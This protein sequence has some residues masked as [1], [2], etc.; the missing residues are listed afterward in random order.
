MNYDLPYLPGVT[1]DEALLAANRFATDSDK[2]IFRSG[3][4]QS[5]PGYVDA[6]TEFKLDGPG[7]GHITW[8]TNRG[9]KTEAAGTAGALYAQK[10]GLWAD[11]TPPAAAL[12]RDA[13]TTVV[14]EAR[15]YFSFTGAHNLSPGQRI[16]LRTAD[17]GGIQFGDD[18]ALVDA[19]YTTSGS[20]LVL[21]NEPGHD[22]AVGDRVTFTGIS[23]INGVNLAGSHYAVV[24]DDNTWGVEVPAIATGSSFGGGAFTVSHAPLFVVETVVDADTITVAAP[25]PASAS[26]TAAWTVAIAFLKPGLTNGI[27]PGGYGEGGYGTGPYGIDAVPANKSFFRPRNWALDTWGEDLLANPMGG[28]L[29][30]WSPVLSQRAALVPNAPAQIDFMFVTDNRQVMC[31][32]CTNTGGIYDPMLV[33]WSE[34]ED[35]ELWFPSDT[36]LAGDLRLQQGSELIGAIN[37]NSGFVILSD[38]SLYTGR[39]TGDFA[40]VY[41]IDF[42]AGECGLIAPRALT[43]KDGKVHWMTKTGFYSYESGIPKRAN[44]PVDVWVIAQLSQR[45][46]FKIHA[47]TDA[48]DPAVIWFYPEGREIDR[49]VRFDFDQGR[50]DLGWSVGT[51]DMTTWVGVAQSVYDKPRAIRVDGMVCQHRTGTTAAGETW[52]WRIEYPPIE[53]TADMSGDGVGPA[54][55]VLN[56]SEFIFDSIIT[57]EVNLQVTYRRDIDSRLLVRELGPMTAT[58]KRRSFKASGRY[59]GMNVS[60]GSLGAT[61]RMG[62][63]KINVTPGGRR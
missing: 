33:R 38:T 56:A 37:T 22:I 55:R 8:A 1:K 49:Y 40:S 39:Y 32:G 18:H 63:V 48:E 62:N 43:E 45:D 15:G 30:A 16:A 61:W 41:Q 25:T 6:S 47:G 17:A 27:D 19:A 46:L 12:T 5:M 4:P 14:G 7:R 26:T 20:G 50:E 2:I 58:T 59:V 28:G 42:V 36:N 29:Y 52:D 13:F 23:V 44:C 34:V 54:G 3:K 60:S 21:I 57:G 24:V 31:L 35:R 53:M 10:D 51:M 9:D 11:I